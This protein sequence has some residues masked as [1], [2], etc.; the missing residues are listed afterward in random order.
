MTNSTKSKDA[1]KNINKIIL[2]ILSVRFIFSCLLNIKNPFFF[3]LVCIKKL[4][5]YKKIAKPPKNSPQSIKSV[6]I[7]ESLNSYS[8]FI[9]IK[10]AFLK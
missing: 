9:I 7:N 4:F 5:W 3:L 10:S 2:K 6:N 1:E 8:V